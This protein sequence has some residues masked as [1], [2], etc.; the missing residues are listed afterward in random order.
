MQKRA[1]S[2]AVLSVVGAVIKFLQLMAFLFISAE[3]KW[4]KDVIQP[5]KVLSL[6]PSPAGWFKVLSPT[7]LIVLFFICFV[8]VTLFCSLMVFTVRNFLRG[9]IPSLAPLRVLAS[10]GK[11][12]CT[13]TTAV[14]DTIGPCC[15]SGCAPFA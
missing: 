3:F 9:Q 1:H 7:F 8:W 6:V 2:N 5:I 4:D 12:L 11:F 13:S 14:V 15:A 10:I